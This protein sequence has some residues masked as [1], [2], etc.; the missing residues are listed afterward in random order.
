MI[1]PLPQ[2]NPLSG[3]PVSKEETI[4]PED[5]IQAV[6]TEFES[7]FVDMM[8]RAMR[9]SVP[10]SEFMGGGHAEDI[11]TGLLDTEYAK[12][13]AAQGQSGLAAVI[14]EQMRGSMPQKEVTDL[15]NTGGREAYEIMS[16]LKLGSS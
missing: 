2:G 10:R 6:A 1:Q 4:R 3:K 12:I 13:I 15:R 16:R 14:A 7:L 5:K 9:S 8:L 11:Y